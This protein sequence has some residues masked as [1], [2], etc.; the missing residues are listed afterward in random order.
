MDIINLDKLTA[1]YRPIFDS[2]N[3]RQITS[4]FSFTL[5]Q[6]L[7]LLA[8]SGR[9]FLYVAGEENAVLVTELLTQYGVRALTLPAE[10]DPI[11]HRQSTAQALTAAR[12]DALVKW[13]TG[14]LDALVVSPEVL[15]GYLPRREEFLSRI[16]TVKVGEEREL[17]SFVAELFRCGYRREERAEQKGS[18]AVNGDIIEV[19][20]IDSPLPVR[21]MTE[22][23]I[24]ESI[25]YY[26]PETM[27]TVRKA[28]KA[29]IPPAADIILPPEAT[30]GLIAAIRRG[31][32]AQNAK[33][34]IRTE[35]ILSDIELRLGLGADS[36]LN[37]LRPF[38]LPY[39]STIFDYL[40]PTDVIVID[41]RKNALDKLRNYYYSVAEKVRRLIPEGE[42]LKKHLDALVPR[43]T[44]D[45]GFACHP[46]LEFS[47]YQ[48]GYADE[49]NGFFVRDSR[50]IPSYF[51]NL[52]L[53]SKDVED[54]LS[55]GYTIC[56]FGGSEE[57]VASLKTFFGDKAQYRT[58]K[59]Q[60]GFIDRTYRVMA[61]GTADMNL[62]IGR[63]GDEVRERRSIA[64]RVGDYVVHEEYGIGRCLGVEHVKSYVGEHDYLVLQYAGEKK[65][66]VPVHQ[67]DMLSL[68]SG[69]ETNPPLSN[70][71]KGDF[72]KEKE[73]AKKSIKK[74]AIDLLE[75]YAKREESKGF[76]YPADSPLQTEF[77]DAFEFEETPDQLSAIAEIKKDMESGRVMD[78]LLCGDV[79]FGKT[80]VALRAIFKT[81]AEGR[82]CAL[83]APTTILAEQHF[84]TASSRLA[85][86]GIRVACLTRFRTKEETQS[87]LAGVAAGTVG[88]VIG[89][90]RLLSKDVA[91]CDLGLLVQDEEQRFGVEQKEKL[92]L[93]RTNVNVLSMSATPIPRT[94]DMALSGIRDIS[95][96]D[97]PPKG[98]Q[99]VQTIVA[100]YTDALLKEAVSAELTRGGQAFVLCNNVERLGGF[101]SHVQELFPTAKIVTGHGK[102]DASVLEKNIYSFYNKDANIL[103]STTIIENG[104]D[105]P[106][107]NTLVVLDADRLG[108]SQMYQLKG[109]VGRSSRLAS[110]YFTYPENKILDTL[111][112][113]RLEALTDNT[114]LGSGYRLAMM[115]LEIRGA[116]NVLG[117]EQHGNV[118]KIGYDMYCKLLKETVAVLK[119]EAVSDYTE[120]EVCVRTDAYISE[121]YV[122][123]ERERLKLY[124]R[125][126]EI[127]GNDDK[128]QLLSDIEELYGTVPKA[129]KNL[130]D[131]SLLRVLGSK[132]G[133]VK[134]VADE[135]GCRVVWKNADYLKSAAV[136]AAE[137]SAAA[138]SV[139]KHPDAV[140]CA[141]GGVGGGIGGKTAFLIKFLSNANGI[142]I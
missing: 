121:D 44:V 11:M 66:F 56:M 52:G 133:A 131:V 85:P 45:A 64:P 33:A 104:I 99:A 129:V 83:L 63:R 130:A 7:H 57:G 55:R 48:A 75:L 43:D 110:A 13:L 123:S 84:M 18:F 124:K 139:V 32:G 31:L 97:T 115:D 1:S 81:L 47:N 137:R 42:A 112:R 88:L 76:R 74:L 22:F 27:T 87:I 70:P 21:I 37:W 35:E 61:V 59:L 65:I 90:H 23:D 20:P 8:V 34:Q 80:E 82:Q 122:R 119:G 142:I 94:L 95:V 68:Y 73:K 17:S 50:A 93:M 136:A 46:N 62:K 26:Q 113:K 79:G 114:E 107:A 92:K 127:S 78:R 30:E 106:D 100:E 135:S 118:E 2:L 53:L 58:D 6:K 105:I 98:R 19:F 91:F 101:A 109:R 96:L 117:R 132:I 10:Y 116:G 24:V 49:A 77:E 51:A 102:M 3:K 72:V 138:H 71:D 89:T 108:L 41:E 25:K 39:L 120:A 28:D 126:A 15:S 40:E 4:A 125:I 60:R 141:F 67:M 16:L 29:V 38:V 5:S 103:V 54:Y 69:R 134:I 140:T 36:A 12:V 9:R 86:F 14:D 128:E 111:A